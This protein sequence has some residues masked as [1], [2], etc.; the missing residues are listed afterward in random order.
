MP[1]RDREESA[2]PAPNR[3]HNELLQDVRGQR[4]LDGVRRHLPTWSGGCRRAHPHGILR[5]RGG[6]ERATALQGD[7]PVKQLRVHGP[8]D[9][10]LDEMP[11]PAPGPRDALVRMAA[12]GICGTDVSFVHMGGIT[13][14][15]MALGHE[16]A[17]VVEWAGAKWLRRARRPGHGPS[18]RRRAGPAGQRR[19]RG[20]ADAAP[21]RPRG[22]QGATAVP[23]AGPDAAA[24]RS[25]DRAAA[26][27]MQAVNQ[28]ESAQGTRWRFSGAA[29]SA[30]SPIATL[31]D[32]GVDDVVAIDLSPRGANWRSIGAAHVLNPTRAT[33][34]PSWPGCTARRRSCSAR[35]RPPTP[36]SRR[37][38]RTG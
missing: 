36:S 5:T 15:P 29:R 37:R 3:L 1:I 34:G 35:R 2:Q 12:C 18:R 32:R 31:A 6:G 17:G 19:G 33:C 30:S 16:M 7:W 27:G 26:V 25:A 21:P 10:R 23:G 4:S 9:V 13:G 24:C 14:G 11:S 22:G 8:N 38:G 28:A 20:R